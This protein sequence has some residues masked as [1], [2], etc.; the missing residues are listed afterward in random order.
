M[1]LHGFDKNRHG[2]KVRSGTSGIAVSTT[3]GMC[4][5]AGDRTLSEAELES[6]HAW[7]Q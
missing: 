6:V 3:T 5:H 4:A 1:T 2:S 7:H